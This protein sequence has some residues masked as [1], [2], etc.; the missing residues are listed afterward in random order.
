MNLTLE[1]GRVSV[2]LLQCRFANFALQE[3]LQGTLHT[4]PPQPL[5]T[6]ALMFPDSIFVRQALELVRQFSPPFLLNHCARTFMFGVAIGKRNNL[7]FDHEILCLAAL[8]HDLGLTERFRGQES[9]EMVG[10]RV[11]HQHLVECKY[12]ADRAALVHE[13]IALHA[14][15]G[16]ASE[17]E[18]EI[19]LVHLGAGMDVIGAR[20]LSIAPATVEYIVAEWPRLNFK[21]QFA[22]LIAEEAQR[23]PDSHI[24]G[25]CDLGF[26]QRISACE[27]F[28]E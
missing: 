16:I 10:A 5:T 24:A 28:T 17:R 27:R 7:R 22:K 1:L 15:I 26:A 4:E 3:A 11:A 20:A 2:D 13:A 14:A 21:K 6:E 25:H 18:P 19:A 9:F 12:P 23:L 8:M